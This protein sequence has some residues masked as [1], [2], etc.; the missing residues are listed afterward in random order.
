MID[1]VDFLHVEKH[2]SLLQIRSVIL[3]G[4][5]KHSQSSK[6]SKFA[7]S[8]WNISKKKVGDQVDFFARR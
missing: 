4:M 1:K 6:N 8:V 7:M 2:E 5:V 3:M